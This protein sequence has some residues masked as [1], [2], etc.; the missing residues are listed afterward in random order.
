MA[1]FVHNFLHAIKKSALQRQKPAQVP[2]KCVPEVGHIKKCIFLCDADGKEQQWL[3]AFRQA[4]P[5]TE[6]TAVAVVP[7]GLDL[8]ENEHVVYV[9]YKAIGLR[10]N[11]L[12]QRLSTAMNNTYEL[13]VDLVAVS[14]ALPDFI[15]RNT[16]S[17]CKIS[18]AIDKPGID[19]TFDGL[20]KEPA[21][22]KEMVTF[23]Q[24]LN[25]KK[26]VR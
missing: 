22:V 2:N 10:G 16:Q 17:T 7:H 8:Q 19:I 20:W 15:L 18:L 21:S 23:L 9:N 14:E 11:I 4:L 1:E 3:K 6:V 25:A 26:G 24:T 13:L 12:N 5:G